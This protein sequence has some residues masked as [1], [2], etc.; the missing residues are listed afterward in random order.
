MAAIRRPVIALLVVGRPVVRRP[1]VGL[2][3]VGLLVGW[4]A[5][6][7]PVLVGLVGG[8][9]VGGGLVLVGAARGVGGDQWTRRG[10][11]RTLG[12]QIGDQPGELRQL[13]LQPLR[14]PNTGRLDPLQRGH[15]LALNSGQLAPM[16]RRKSPQPLRRLI[17]NVVK[18][19]GDRR[20]GC[21]CVLSPEPLDLARVGLDAL[22]ELLDRLGL[23][24]DLLAQIPRS[25]VRRSGHLDGECHHHCRSDDHDDHEKPLSHASWSSRRSIARR[26]RPESDTVG[27]PDPTRIRVLSGPAF[28]AADVPQPASTSTRRRR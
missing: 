20:T 25:L 26:D 14:L 7:G 4:I 16:R 3:V 15:G 13:H 27:P 11:L 5:V 12:A 8:G 19:I 9:L 18:P 28:G 21:A 22:V 1:V 2:L 23:R 6:G 10:R 24:V 17:E